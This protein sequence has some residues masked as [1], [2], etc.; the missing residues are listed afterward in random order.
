MVLLA[1]ALFFAIRCR[2]EVAAWVRDFLAMVRGWFA[3]DE[4]GTTADMLGTEGRSEKQPIRFSDL[5]NP[6]SI[7]AGDPDGAVKALFE[8]ACVWGREHRVERREDETPEEYVIRLGRKYSAIAEPLSRLGRVYSRLAYA[9]K[10]V[11]ISDVPALQPLW[12][13]MV[14]HPTR[15]ASNHA[16]LK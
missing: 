4:Q 6:F 9:Q 13:W 8:A 15:S 10:R 12:S 7:H 3:R 5:S 2:R 14:Q 11:P 16:I 1:L